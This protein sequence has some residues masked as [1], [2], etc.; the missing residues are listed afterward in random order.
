MNFQ[1]IDIDK[2]I[3]KVKIELRDLIISRNEI[4]FS[5]GYD[6]GEIPEHF[7]EIIDDILLQ[8]PNR[9]EVKAGYRILDLTNPADRNDGIIVGGIF[10]RT[11]RIVTSQL[12]N[13]EKAA[14]F[15]CTIGPGMEMWSK[16]LLS[17]GDPTMSYFVDTIA[18]VTVESVTNL[19]HDCIGQKMNE[20]GLKIT[21]RYSP[22][23]CNWSVA[24][25]QLLFSLLPEN[26]CSVSLTES[27]LMLPIKSTS[28]IIGIGKAV[29]WKE[30]L[31]DKCGMKDCTYR[32]K[33]WKSKSK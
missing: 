8:V 20:Q 2:N 31:C 28:G 14:L 21:N 30:Y 17:D 33:R 32:A 29:E 26:F 4:E 15:L 3:F 13:S 19:L 5:L 25:Q 1:V 7:I 16:K 18:S 12:K 9:C 24:E 22:G 10:F 11:D 23:Y 6:E 27:S